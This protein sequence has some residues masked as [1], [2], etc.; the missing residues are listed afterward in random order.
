MA[1][2]R[3]CL[4]SPSKSS[5]ITALGLVPV[6]KSAFAANESVPEVLVFRKTE[7][8]FEPAFATM[9][10]LFPLP[11]ISAILTEYGLLPVA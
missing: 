10:S 1:I 9:R 6:A 3:S 11:S 2:A 5:T 4:P 7:T 8:V